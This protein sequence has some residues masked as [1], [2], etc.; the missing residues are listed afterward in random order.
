M[1]PLTPAEQLDRLQQIA[2]AAKDLAS[3][4]R[5][6]FPVQGEEWYPTPTDDCV[7]SVLNSQLALENLLYPTESPVQAPPPKSPAKGKQAAPLPRLLTP[8]DRKY[9]SGSVAVCQVLGPGSW[10]EFS[11]DVQ[12][13]MSFHDRILDHYKWF[14]WIVNLCSTMPWKWPDV[15]PIPAALFDGFNRAVDSLESH[16]KQVEELARKAG[17]GRDPGKTGQGRPRRTP[18]RKARQSQI[19]SKWQRFYE[20]KCWQGE[21]GTPKSQFCERESIEREE[22]ETA[23][24]SRRA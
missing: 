19:A 2:F 18:E 8:K 14:D 5:R 21:P 23:L 24:R 9:R 4:I 3:K 15:R 12:R 6:N 10:Q 16:V 7:P 1:S 11:L 22:L 17:A 20:S 13:V